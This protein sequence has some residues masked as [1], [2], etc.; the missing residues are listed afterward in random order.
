MLGLKYIPLG[1]KIDIK[2]DVKWADRYT[3][4]KF[5]GEIRFTDTNLTIIEKQPWDLTQI[6]N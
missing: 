6:E 3:R 1:D 5:R 4:L 2:R